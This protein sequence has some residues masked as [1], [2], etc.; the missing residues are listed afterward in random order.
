MGE[1]RRRKLNKNYEFEQLN[2]ELASLGIDTD[3][4]GFFDQDEF[5]SQEQRD[6][7]FLEKYARWVDLRPRDAAY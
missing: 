2:G 3:N 1:A 5:V 4:F 7:R 6:P